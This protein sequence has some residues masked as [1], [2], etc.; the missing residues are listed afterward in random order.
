MF[1]LASYQ[2]SGAQNPGAG[3]NFL[4]FLGNE[5]GFLT[6]GGTPGIPGCADPAGDWTGFLNA[7]QTLSNDTAGTSQASSDAQ[8]TQAAFS[9]FKKELAKTAP[10][11]VLKGDDA[12][13]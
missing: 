3:Q 7:A 13:S 12:T 8:A 10:G 2:Q 9:G 1:D 5:A 6:N 11:V 4:T